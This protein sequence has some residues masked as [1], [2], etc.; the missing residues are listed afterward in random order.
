M[1]TAEKEQLKKKLSTW[2]AE[3]GATNQ[4]RS[5]NKPQGGEVN[6]IYINVNVLNKVW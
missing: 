3:D 2:I 6:L 4:Q 5:D 1:V